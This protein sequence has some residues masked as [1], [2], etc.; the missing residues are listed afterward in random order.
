MTPSVSLFDANV[1][2]GPLAH[3][4]PGAPET[5]ADLREP[6][7]AYGVSRALVTH[8]LAKWSS[9]A[10][11]N[12]RLAEAL[13][14]QDRLV[15]CWVVLPAA[16]GEVPPEAEQV[17]RLL[18]SGARAARLCPVAHRLS[19]EPWEVDRLLG[20]L[21]ERRVPLLLDFDNTHWSE[22][23]P[24]RF[25]EWAGRTYP[26]LPLVLL[27]EPQAN[28]RTLFPL[29][30]RCPNLILET[31]YFQ[32]LEGILLLAERCGPHRLVFGTGRPVGD[33]TLP[34]TGLA[35]A[36]LSP[37]AL[38]GIAGGTLQA[39]LAGCVLS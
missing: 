36:G 37:E 1:L 24:W 39:L 22:A 15:G 23:R 29:L 7:D 14:G 9:P 2:L 35:Y 33:P 31:S 11:G 38:A 34:L 27:R 26:D 3:R 19:C 28:L 12:R 4:P 18:A 21:Q 20:A 17:Q 13:G 6:L 10:D 25:L 32:A 16:T 5:L 30:D 8:T